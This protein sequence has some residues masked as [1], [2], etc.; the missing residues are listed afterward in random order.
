MHIFQSQNA[1]KISVFSTLL[2]VLALAGVTT[3]AAACGFGTA[4]T[5]TPAPVTLRYVTFTGLDAAEETL[6]RQF[7]ADNPHVTITAE[8]YAQAPDRYLA[9]APVP[10]LMLITPGQI[11]DAAIAR[12]ALTD[13]TE[14]WQESGAEQEFVGSLRALSQHE[15]KQ[16]YLPVGYSWNGIYYN[17]Q[18]FEQ[19]G[20]QPPQNWDEFVQLCE[21]LW[22]NGVT[23]LAVS[24]ND[25]F[26]GTLWLD[27]L[28]LRLNGP[29]FHQQFLNGEIRYD[30][31]RVRSVFELWA[32]LVEK[33][34]F[35]PTASTM[36]IDAA[37]SAVAQ[38]GNT[39]GTPVAMLLSGPAFMGDLSP[40]QRS[41]LGF[42]PFPT[43]D[44]TQ[45]PAEVVMSIGYMVPAQAPQRDEALAFVSYLASKQG[46]DLLSKDVAA[47]G[48]YAPAFAAEGE[49]LPE[50]VRQGME[51]VQQTDAVTVPYYMS[52]SPQ[53]WP[54]LADMLK[55]ILTE[56]GSGKGFDLDALL[57]R[58]E[59]AR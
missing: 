19:Y 13:L 6:I 27:Y 16:F 17:K 36:G 5:P 49:T 25:P 8:E 53:M 35:M 14:L 22:I 34:Y 48:L 20:L 21:T 23:P 59:A 11:L 28:N 43:L 58:L 33:G 52:V 2:R 47:T 55:R 50:S 46:R 54:A 39:S 18:L 3:M 32:S 7:Q 42:F 12:G 41:A 38:A 29:E 24:G 40:E 45:T 57:S 37:L 15:G 10:E 26:M 51:L 1:P 56:P 4:P 31:P 30:D 44:P 9:S